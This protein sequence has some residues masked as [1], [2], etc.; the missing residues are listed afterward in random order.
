MDYPRE[1]IKSLESNVEY[2]IEEVSKINNDIEKEI[3]TYNPQDTKH[4]LIE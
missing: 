1:L 3:E 2:L 4:H